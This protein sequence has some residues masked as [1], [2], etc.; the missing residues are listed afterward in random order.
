MKSSSWGLTLKSRRDERPQTGVS[1]PGSSATTKEAPTGR[2]RPK[3]VAIKHVICSVALSGLSFVN[4]IGPGVDT[5]VCSLSRLRRFSP[6]TN[7]FNYLS[8]EGRQN[9]ARRLACFH[10]SAG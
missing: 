5:P 10:S 7:N 9:A 3:H 4:A 8:R 6:D 1:T 2:Q